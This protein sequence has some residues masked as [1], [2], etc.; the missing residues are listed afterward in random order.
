MRKIMAFYKTKTP[1]NPDKF[2]LDHKIHLKLI[3]IF[4]K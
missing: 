2:S 1:K 3:L 4:I